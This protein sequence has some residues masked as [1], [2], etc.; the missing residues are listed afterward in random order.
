MS[1]LGKEPIIAILIDNYMLLFLPDTFSLPGTWAAQ[2]EC[3]WQEQCAQQEQLNYKSIME[4]IYYIAT[5]RPLKL[6]FSI[7]NIYY[8]RN[9]L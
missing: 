5:Q 6:F 3:A 1:Y 9:K 4:V 7:L 8:K 2:R